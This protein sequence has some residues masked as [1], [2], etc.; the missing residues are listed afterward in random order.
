MFISSKSWAPGDSKELVC[1]VNPIF[2]ELKE[3]IN[4]YF[5]QSE[6]ADNSQK[7]N[8]NDQYA[9]EKK[10]AHNSVNKNFC[11]SNNRIS[12]YLSNRQSF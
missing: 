4:K 11:S 6:R 1:L 10:K 9:H 8:A 5:L 12:F 3:N 2:L 7:K